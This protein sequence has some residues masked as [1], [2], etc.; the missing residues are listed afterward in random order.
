MACSVLILTY[1][2]QAAGNG[3]VCCVV[4]ELDHGHGRGIGAKSTYPWRKQ[5]VVV[6]IFHLLDTV[7]NGG[8]CL[9]TT[10]LGTTSS[11]TSVARRVLVD[12]LGDPRPQE[13]LLLHIGAAPLVIHVLPPR[14]A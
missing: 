2:A 10:G 7:H 13:L 6:R 5:E 8:I 3:L 12:D 14:V 11:A 1:Q 9:A 4:S